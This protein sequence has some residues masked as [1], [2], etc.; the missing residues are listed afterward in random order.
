MIAIEEL[1]PDHFELVSN[2]LSTTEINQWLTSEWR[3]RVVTP[4]LVALVVRNKRNRAFLV[5]CNGHACGLV[6]LTD[7]DAMDRTAMIWYV[8]GD[9]A[10]AGRGI[11]SQAVVQVA[12][13][14]WNQLGLASL[15]AWIMD[16][17]AASKRVLQK[18]GFREAG[19]I[20]IA[21]HHNGHQVDRIYFD[22][23]AREMS[24]MPDA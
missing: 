8:L 12:G 3:N 16:G 20:R 1:A 6:A 17:N 24:G 7:I 4:A 13:M 21:A 23:T 15:Y 10:L 14:C 2:W 9:T 18:A 11:I 19:R 22:L 5:R